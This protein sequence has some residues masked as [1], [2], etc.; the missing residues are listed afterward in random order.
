M[1]TVTVDFSVTDVVFQT[2]RTETGF[3]V[4][5][6]SEFEVFFLVMSSNT[7]TASTSGRSLTGLN[8]S[9]LLCK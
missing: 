4:Q 3:N 1:A 6:T 9:T 7:L 8:C 5:E 2:Q